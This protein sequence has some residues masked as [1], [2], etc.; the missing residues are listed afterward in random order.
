QAAGNDGLSNLLFIHCCECL[1]H[2]LTKIFRAT[3]K[4]KHYPNE[5]Q[6]SLTIILCK[7]VKPDYSKSKAAYWPITL[8]VAI[9]KIPSSAMAELLLYMVE[10]RALLPPNSFGG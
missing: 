7:D 9:T 10:K 2:K 8:P 6:E 5:W 1:V 4:L 3:F